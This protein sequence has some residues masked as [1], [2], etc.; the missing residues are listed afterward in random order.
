MVARDANSGKETS[1]DT[2]N[3]KTLA[4]EI[5]VRGTLSNALPYESGPVFPGVP[6]DVTMKNLTTNDSTEYHVTTDA[7]GNYTVKVT[8]GTG[9]NYGF[10]ID[11]KSS[12]LYNYLRRFSIAS[13][14]SINNKEEDIVDFERA[15]IPEDPLPGYEELKDRYK[16]F[17]FTQLAN[18]LSPDVTWVFGW[19]PEDYPL[20]MFYTGRFNDSSSAVADRGVNKFESK[21]NHDSYKK[22]LAE[23]EIGVVVEFGNG[24]G[25]FPVEWAFDNNGKILYP[26][27]WKIIL[28]TDSLGNPQFTE[29][30]VIHELQY[31]ERAS[32][33]S[34][35]FSSFA[36]FG[37]PFGPA[38]VGNE[39]K[40][41]E[42]DNIT[43][44][45]NLPRTYVK[46]FLLYN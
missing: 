9:V 7:S 19:R 34:I 45:R 2:L 25:S 32:D 37:W 16:L 28:P 39:I 4:A 6:I 42:I 18:Q 43:I 21:I 5:Y 22:V 27:K 38:G 1:S 10:R 30:F 36:G 31:V 11:L 13:R 40:Q 24:L 41:A 12:V 35:P 26:I 20:S 14:D 33:Q 15:T 46:R 23:P 44:E 3:A 29:S 17:E 8:L